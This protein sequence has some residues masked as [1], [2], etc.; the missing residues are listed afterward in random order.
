MKKTIDVN[1]NN[2][3]FHIDDDAYDLLRNYLNEIEGYLSAEER[4]EVMFDIEARVAEL[5]TERLNKSG[6][7]VVNLEDVESVIT[8]LGKPN[9]YADQDD[10]SQPAGESYEP[11]QNK[12]RKFYRDP[13]LAILGGVA[14]GTAAFLGWS[15]VLVRILFILLFI[16]SSG[17]MTIVYLIMWII[18]PAAYSVSQ[19]LEMQGESVTADR[20]KEEFNNAKSYVNSDQFRENASSVGNKVGNV[21]RPIFKLFMIIIASILGFVGLIVVE[22]ILLALMV[23][24]FVPGISMAVLPEIFTQNMTVLSVESTIMLVLS[25]LLMVGGPIVL[26]I[27][28]AVNAL[29]NRKSSSKTFLW[30]VL[31]LWLAG[32]FMFAGLGTKAINSFDNLSFEDVQI[33]LTE[34]SSQNVDKVFP[35]EE[36]YGIYTQGAFEIELSQGNVQSVQVNAPED[37]MD[38][39]HVSVEDHILKINTDKIYK[40]K[41]IKVYVVNPSFLK[42]KAEGA[43]KIE[44]RNPIVTDNLELDLYGASKIDLD[45]LKAGYVD[46][47]LYGA[48]AAAFSGEARKM[49]AKVEGVSKIEADKLYLKAADLRVDGASH[50][51]L[52]VTDSIWIEAN[53]ASKVECTPRPKF[54]KEE[55]FGASKIKF[56]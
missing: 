10:E 44:A 11:K 45:S 40:N 48:G 30:V 52:H 13:Q 25:I 54:V 23:A 3:V 27:Y 15:V 8:V 16:I 5:F 37:I 38:D 32:I 22:V 24:V 41:H 50:V 20:I 35:S 47:E 12:S 55:V 14:A 26:I 36:F 51:S 31:I 56:N 2:I 49:K 39:I 7:N 18:A 43:S 46:L 53:G 17:T 34:N 6:K 42:I 28:W 9:Q 33:D 4:K 1:L 19:R 29:N 21:V